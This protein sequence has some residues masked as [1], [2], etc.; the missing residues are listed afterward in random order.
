[1]RKRYGIDSAE[2]ME[3]A[4]DWAKLK[5]GDDTSIQFS[6]EIVAERNE[7][8]RELRKQTKSR[9][10]SAGLFKLVKEG[11]NEG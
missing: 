8:A 7:R 11:V 3:N 4:L 9:H 2:A 1:M 10:H 6:E 5:Y